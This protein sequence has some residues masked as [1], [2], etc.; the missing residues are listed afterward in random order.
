MSTVR[1]VYLYLVAFVSLHVAAFGAADLSRAVIESVAFSTDLVSSNLRRDVALN[2][3]YLLVGLPLW[4]VHWRWAAR[5][6]GTDFQERAATL[7]RLYVYLVLAIMLAAI[8]S[9]SQNVLEALFRAVT[10]EDRSGTF[11][12][13]R[14]IVNQ[15]PWLLVGAALWVYHRRTAEQ[16]R[17]AA[18]EDQGSATLRRWYIYGVA[19]VAAMYLLRNASRVLR[20]A[21]ESVA[22]AATGSFISSQSSGLAGAAATALIAIAVWAL[23]WSLAA[24]GKPREQ[25]S[26]QDSRSTLRPVYLFGAL[27]VCVA[28]TLAGLS[29]LLYYALGRLLGVSDPGG[30]GGNL[31]VAMAGPTSSALVF[32]A[33][34]LYQR[35]SVSRQA[36]SQDELPR[37]AGVRRLYVYLVALLAIAVMASGAGGLLWTIADLSTSAPRAVSSAQWWR[38][39]VSLYATLLIAGL[40]VWVIHWGP[41]AS[42]PGGARSLARRIYLYVTLGA[43][44]LSLLGA[45]VA[46]A[47]E[48][49]LLVLGEAATASAVTN[50]ARA[51]SVAVIAGLVVAYHQRILRRDLATPSAPATHR[52]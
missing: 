2:G 24:T 12:T 38:E 7:R 5:A 47:R 10:G 22:G 50:L 13:G 25:L 32:G 34:W 30:V 39:Q 11:S 9:A 44:V 37:Q 28:A 49:L 23:H 43:A 6:A 40:P 14:E 41:V 31:L 15:I 4:L 29:Q 42:D 51:F 46:A 21:W 3:A 48:I 36:Q 20:L 18:G 35:R 1:R 26:G 19:F 33:G 52:E 17:L 27:A 45:G 16:D 8:A